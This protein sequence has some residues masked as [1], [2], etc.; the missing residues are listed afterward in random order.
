MRAVAI[1]L[2][3]VLRK[4]LDIEAQDFGAALLYK[5]LQQA[6]RVVV[7]GTDN[8]ER[9]EQFLAINGLGGYVKI[10]PLRPE[11]GDDQRDQAW[12]QVTRLRNEGFVFEFVVVPD[13]VLAHDLYRVG[14]PT[15]VYL[16]PLYSGR[17]LRPDTEPGMT[18]WSELADAVEFQLLAKARAR[19]EAQA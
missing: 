6:F 18:P 12:G 2:D 15:L 16:H 14:I 9:D 1:S 3:G 17:D 19:E 7:L 13:P 10:E 11:D 4:P 5:T 8:P